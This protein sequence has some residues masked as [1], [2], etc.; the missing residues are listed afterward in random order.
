M[1]CSSAR[2]HGVEQM[3]ELRGVLGH[4]ACTFQA[5]PRVTKNQGTGQSLLAQPRQLVA[6]QCRGCSRIWKPHGFQNT[7]RRSEPCFLHPRLQ[8]DG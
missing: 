3:A 5:W 2:P 4:A 8:P 7:K 1:L 6:T